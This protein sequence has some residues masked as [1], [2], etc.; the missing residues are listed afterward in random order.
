MEVVD[1]NF[2]AIGENLKSYLDGSETFEILERDDGHIFSKVGIHIYFEGYDKWT[3]IQKNAIELVSGRILDVGAGAGRISLH[4]QSQG[5]DV[6]AV[7]N[8]PGAIEVCRKRGILKPL[9]VSIEDLTKMSSWEYDTILMLGNNFGLLQNDNL[10][11][12]ILRAMHKITKPHAIVLAESMNI[13]GAPDEIHQKY[14]SHNKERNRLPGQLRLR[15]LSETITGN[16]F[17]FLLVTLD[18]MTTIL[19]RNGWRIRQVLGDPSFQYVA[20]VEKT[21]KNNFS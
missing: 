15:V 16:W 12:Q 2:D 3:T 8:S 9:L 21:D 14:F 18:E 20:V 17:D 10:A 19:R 5:F 4:L 1:A 13:L 7:D 11:D 6:T